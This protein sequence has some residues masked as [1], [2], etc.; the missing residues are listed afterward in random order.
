M[1]NKAKKEFTNYLKKYIREE[2]ETIKLTDDF[3]LLNS[4]DLDIAYRYYMCALKNLIFD[5]NRKPPRRVRNIKVKNQIILN[6]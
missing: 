5:I 6:Q 4:A 3:C 2:K 1:T